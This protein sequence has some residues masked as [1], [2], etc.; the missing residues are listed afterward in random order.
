MSKTCFKC[1]IDKPLS[2]FYAHSEMKDGFLN[3]CKSCTR[4]DVKE[5]GNKYDFTEKGVIRVIYKTQKR[6]SIKRKMSAPN[7]SK[8]EFSKWL[9]S[10]GFKNLY[11]E[12]VLSNHDKFKKP[13]CDRIDDYKP[14]SFCNIKLVTWEDNIRHF[15]DDTINGTGK[16]GKKCKKV[17]QFDSNMLLIAEYVSYSSAKRINNF[18]M[19]RSIKSGKKDR[20]GYFWKYKE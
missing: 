7:Y 9:Y 4:K 15:A 3:K 10:N 8:K 11:D 14:Y 20:N 12:W 18:C 6:N 19:E 13:S 2:E 1:G 16:C 17:L 5:N